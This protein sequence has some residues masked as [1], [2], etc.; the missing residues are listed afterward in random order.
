MYASKE[1]FGGQRAS[2]GRV[3]VMRDGL[4]DDVEAGV[5]TRI[6]TTGRMVITSSYSGGDYDGL[7][8][9]ETK[10]EADVD[11]LPPGAWTWPVRV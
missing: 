3:V 8:F 6:P 2:V 5:I 4:D 1:P 11:K 10:T 7:S 9:V